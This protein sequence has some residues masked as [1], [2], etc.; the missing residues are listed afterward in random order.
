MYSAM[1]T[2]ERNPPSASER[3]FLWTTIAIGAAATLA[4]C[5]LVA[6]RNLVMGSVRGGWFYGYAAPF[7]PWLIVVFLAASAIVIVALLVTSAATSRRA[8]LSLILW[9]AAATAAHA[10]IRSPGRFTL[11]QIFLSPGA[12]AFYTV[13][14]EFE[15]Y[16]V[17]HRTKRLRE[18][19]P[20]HALSNMPGKVMTVHALRM[21]STRTDVLPWLIVVISNLGAVLMYLF[22]KD[23]FNDR[24]TALVAA[25]LYLFVPARIFFFPLMNTVTPVLILGCACLLTRW[26][27]TGATIFPALLGIALFAVAF[28]EPLPFVMG[29][30]FAAFSIRA[31]VRREIAWDR[32]AAQVVL[33]VLLFVA[34]AELVSGLTGFSLF[35]MMREIGGHAVEFNVLAGRRYDIW[36]TANLR[37]FLFGAG[38][39]QAVLF[40]GGLVHSVRGGA[41][42][43]ERLTRPEAVACMSVL[44][45][46]L[47]VDLIGV[48]RGEVIRLWIFLACFLQ[49]PAAYACAA[50][51]GRTA[52][53]V[54]LV[55]SLLQ[56]VL[57]SAMIE[58][59]V[60]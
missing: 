7:S 28:F 59:V 40:A 17:L 2:F 50:L 26:L 51:G 60:P 19:A 20:L 58:F 23:V 42:W 34:S 3:R 46:L 41:N 31:I 18:N 39:C 9:I 47:A 36:V 4:V 55:C 10:V 30:L 15:L 1:E 14:R 27:H 57:G 13:A 52:I 48:N 12:N 56:A 35:L 25:I 49:I 22:V 6:S 29:L 33:M 32:Y 44:A 21:V 37:E 43:W 45:V 8:W 16:D 24:W 5:V 38:I 11:E 54:P 53:A